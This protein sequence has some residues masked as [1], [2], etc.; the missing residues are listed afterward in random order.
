MDLSNLTAS[1]NPDGGWS[2]RSGGSATEPTALALLALAASGEQRASAFLRGAD[3]LRRTQRPDGGWAPR[4]NVERSTW[5]TSLALL[6]PMDGLGVRRE[7]AVQWVV[8]TSG[9]ET[10]WIQ[11]LRTSLTQGRAVS[12][13]G[14]GFSWYPE[15]SAWVTPTCFGILALRKSVRGNGSRDI[16]ARCDSACSFL[17]AHSCQ[18]GGWNYGSTDSPGYETVS[19]PE[20][21]GQALLALH[22]TPSQR[23][24]LALERA[25]RDVRQCRSL[26]AMSWLKLGLVA[27][28][29][30]LPL[31][32]EPRGNGSVPEISLAILADA[33]AG[34]RNV[35]L[36]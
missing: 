31:C 9:R 11:R 27:H 34:G 19:Y 4:P 14:A 8:R 20:T 13:S 16:I 2:Y 36:E 26:E 1:Q 5:V 32:R 22:R 7:A 15:T 33:A 10:S 24:A 30:K 18:D 25:A 35:F 3:W 17:L 23:I 28:G 6:V 29:L 21:T 12:G